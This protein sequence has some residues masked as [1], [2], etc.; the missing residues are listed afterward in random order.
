[1][2]KNIRLMMLIVGIIFFVKD[3]QNSGALFSDLIAN[4]PLV[5][6]QEQVPAAPKPLRI[7]SYGPKGEVDGQ[8]QVKITFSNPLTPLTSL[9]DAEREVILRN[10]AIEPAI[11][12]RFRMLGSSI[13]VFEPE[14]SLPMA[15]T[16]HV[17]VFDD[18]RDIHGGKLKKSLKWEF[19]TPRPNVSIWP[20]NGV[21]HVKLEVITQIRAS[22]ALNVKS[23]QKKVKWIN[24]KTGE[25]LAFT[26]REGSDN[27]SIQDTGHRRMRYRY[28][29][30]PKQ[31]LERDT[32][33]SIE[34]KAG[35]L[36][37][38]G[39]RPTTSKIISTF[40]T[41]PPFR[42]VENGNCPDCGGTVTTLPHLIFSNI[43]N[44]N[45]WSDF[46]TFTPAFEKWPL[47]LNR[48]DNDNAER[49]VHFHNHLL[50]PNTQYA[51][52]LKPG[53]MDI[54]GQTLENPQT[55]SFTTGLYSP[56][57]MAPR[58]FQI[59]SPNVKP[60]LEVKV[61]SIEKI[62][63]KLQPLRPQD[64]LVKENL[65]YQNVMSA[66]TGNPTFYFQ[67]MQVPLNADGVGGVSYD[68]RPLLNG[69]EYGAL[70]YSIESPD[71]QCHPKPFTYNGLLLRTNLG[72][73]TQFYP[74]TG[75]IKINQ[76]T[77]GQS[78][79]DARVKV[80]MTDNL[81]PINQISQLI[82][83][84][85]IDDLEPCFSGVT[86]E[87]GMLTLLAGEMD[88]CGNRKDDDKGIGEL[89]PPQTDLNDILHNQQKYGF[90]EPPNLLIVVEKDDDW[91]FLRTTK[92][93]NPNLWRF[94][95][96]QAWEA[97]DPIVRGA[98]FSDHFIYRPGETVKMKGV[99][100][101]LLRGS[102]LN[103][104]G[105]AFNLSLR[106]P[107]GGQTELGKAAPGEFGTFHFDVPTKKGQT[108]GYY[109]VVAHNK[110]HNL[111]LSGTFRLAEF[112]TPEFKV[113]MDVHPKIAL[114]GDSVQVGWTGNYY[115]G[116]PMASAR[117]SLHITRRK[118]AY[119][120]P[121][122]DDFT[123]DIP[124]PVGRKQ[125]AI[126]GR[127]L[128]QSFT[129]D[130]SGRGTRS[131][132][133]LPEDAPFAMTYLCDVEVE[134]ISRQTISSQTSFTALPD[135]RLPGVKLANRIIRKN[136]EAP[137]EIIVSSPTGEALSGVDLYVSLVKEETHSVRLKTVDG[138][139]KIENSVAQKVVSGKPVQSGA[140]PIQLTF[141]PHEAGSYYVLV[142]L[143]DKPG[144]GASVGAMLW[145]SGSEY[146]PWAESGEDKLDI[147]LDKNEYRV[148]DMATAF[149]KSPFP[150][151][152][153]FL[154]VSR[155]AVF[156]Q[157]TK[158]IVGSS[159]TFQFKVTEEML[160]NAFLGAALFRHGDPIVPIEEEI[161]KHLERVGFAPFR[162]SLSEKH[163]DVAVKT[164]RK[165]Y[166]PG[167]LVQVDVQ[168]IS[169]D[170]K[171]VRSELTVM[172]VDDAILSMTGYQPPDLVKIIYAQHG[173][174][175]RL[176]DNR[177][178]IISEQEFL[179]KG[180]GYGGGQEEALNDTKIR[181]DFLKLAYYKADLITSNDGKASFEFKSPDNLTTWRLMVVAV[182]ENNTF[183]YGEEKTLVTQPF[184]IRP[185]LPRFARLGDE[186]QAGIAVTNLT[187]AEGAVK[188]R[189]T[190][191]KGSVVVTDGQAVKKGILLEPGESKTILYPLQARRA[192]ESELEFVATFHGTFDG[193][194]VQNESDAVQIT[195]T[196]QDLVATETVVAVGET[197]ERDSQKIKIDA[198][199][200]KDTGGLNLR[201]ASSSLTNIGEGAKYL[202]SYPYGCLEQTVS[203]LLA[204]IQL[205]Y[206]SDKYQFELN[207]VKDI[208]KVI[209]E[210]IQKVLLLQNHDG[211][212]KFW[213]GSS[214]SSAYLAPYVAY[215]FN[216]CSKFERVIEPKFIDGLRKFLD[217]EL[218][219]PSIINGSWRAVAEFRIQTLVGLRHLNSKDETHFEEYFSKRKQ[220]SY[221]AQIQLASLL[222]QSA[223]WHDEAMVLL[224][225]IENG[226]FITAQSAHFESPRELPNSWRFLSSPVII[227][228]EALKLYLAMDSENENI[229]KFARFL[230]SARKNG[231]W[232]NTYENS[233]AIDALAQVS[234]IRE[235]APPNFS[236]EIELA[237]KTVFAEKYEGFQY[238]PV[239]KEIAMADLP[240]GTHDILIQKKGEGSL[241]YTLSYN[242][243]LKGPQKFR[244]EGFTISRTVRRMENE[245]V[246][247]NYA[248][249]PAETLT[250][251]AG[252]V[253]EIELEYDVPQTAFHVVID[254]A[255]PAGLEVLDTS[256]KTTSSRYQSSKRRARK[257][258]GAS[259]AMINT[260]RR[261]SSPVSHSELRDDSVLLFVDFIEPG[262]YTYKYLARATT[263]GTFLWPS[264]KIQMMYEPEQFGTNAEGMILV[265]QEETHPPAVK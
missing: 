207:S 99:L 57:M 258:K 33:Y 246:L 220:L 36:P 249:A 187:A 206:L 59:I 135:H 123:F 245:E 103:G 32:K 25:S 83:N 166:R 240:Q 72:I 92:W 37:K 164:D 215:L 20:K 223:D 241:F 225:D 31:K 227:T 77:D 43:P 171:G 149:V 167:E 2:T 199:V 175:T 129:L 114:P 188:V 124:R 118:T 169:Y 210:N 157:E 95:V 54:Y 174:S 56:K 116:A 239:E 144:G 15:T 264:A 53:L 49:N 251:Q 68:L 75:M 156:V 194:E 11:Q 122:W 252:D 261:R 3:S 126:S 160:P 218:R 67:E 263:S 108:L 8:A 26:I 211:G 140:E 7:S 235:S 143:A 69:G 181:K 236:A 229:A 145:V 51:V 191:S 78:V 137:V 196:V 5:S 177:S 180:M 97:D 14:S 85:F 250:V 62:F 66:L 6:A 195:L 139:Y 91:T 71:I 34:I 193:L 208:D 256:L 96:S 117:A 18:L 105:L 136:Q 228:A 23:L 79:A 93:G 192:G 94:G 88:S 80:Y 10:F 102:L 63:Y 238:K 39:N 224:Q 178:F 197:R 22:V 161:G 186:F 70:A 262:L 213:P 35:V 120:P 232:K 254:D 217:K 101:Y 84:S 183:G 17:N 184:I 40:K 30:I 86:D 27:A 170:K 222:Q 76:L 73:Y 133:L 28:S 165:K 221:G 212:F 127:Y 121:G 111:Y 226:M 107:R 205:Q 74:T 13:V 21:D 179:Q 1:M 112:R 260:P 203:R 115:F 200:R 42:F 233:K 44:Q 61:S 60:E 100:R 9:S 154:T 209:A 141:T 24:L 125:E 55:I 231:K 162:V 237:G 89:Y 253:L 48:C 142:E 230:L 216:Q 119:R 128:S 152:E 52:V 98:L 19:K 168:A 130:A 214:E 185:V 131:I 134:D 104:E 259:G 47:V 234:L 176:N 202:V 265:L 151:A 244:N 255:V 132:E 138:R 113:A 45:N 198:S 58:G 81:P 242:Y 90:P 204:L 248:E 158:N 16:F 146:A 257:R 190:L 109:R 12:G 173:L 219:N 147:I 50:K 4:I 29:I 64:V 155:D 150:K 153:L 182:G 201:L 189:A 87:S 163:L 82:S 46:F 159:Y 110:K 148:G 106:D 41:Y 243:R 65:A 38:F 172:V 247:A